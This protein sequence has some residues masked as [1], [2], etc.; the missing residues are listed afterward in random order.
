[1]ENKRSTGR[2]ILFWFIFISVFTVVP[3][4]LIEGGARLYMHAK[5]GV[6]GKSYGLWQYDEIL[7]AQHAKNGY[8]SN[9]QTND[10]GFRNNENVLE[11][12][13]KGSL[14]VIA[15]GGST[16]FCYN[17]FNNET[18]TVRLEEMMRAKHNPKDQVLNA[19]AI[20]WSLGHAFARAKKDI[21]VLKPDYVLIY[22]GVNE[23]PNANFLAADGKPLDKLLKE[24]KHGAFATN[25]D[26]CRWEKRNLAI[27]RIIDYFIQPLFG[28]K[29]PSKGEDL[30][31]KDYPVDPDPVIM[32][33]Y[34]LTLKDFFNFVKENGSIPIFVVEAYGLDTQKNRYLTSYSRGGIPVAQ[35]MGV[36]VVNAQEMVNAYPGNK[37]DLFY[38]S[39]VHYSVLG[40]TKLGGYIYENVF[41]QQP[42]GG[43]S[44]TLKD[45]ELPTE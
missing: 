21:P 34:R 12:K 28:S 43:P 15:Y 30:T 3:F 22:A 10:W 13:P 41:A 8:N 32:E 18:W 38:E 31:V 26:Q 2:K 25:F 45:L 27:V 9:A 44:M 11:P 16:T 14:R 29:P 37:M 19:G 33:N 35:E 7:G 1:M 24:G 5:Y 4:L 20:M 42:L 39:G 17:L 36:K 40:A 23:L 6:A